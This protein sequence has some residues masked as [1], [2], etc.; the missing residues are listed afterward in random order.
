M[1]IAETHAGDG[2][3][4]AGGRPVPGRSGHLGV[5]TWFRQAEKVPFGEQ[6]GGPCQ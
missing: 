3:A 1:K 4:T 5:L 2:S 6:R